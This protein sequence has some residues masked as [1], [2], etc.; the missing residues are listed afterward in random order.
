MVANLSGRSPEFY[1]YLEKLKVKTHAVKEKIR[2]DTL[3]ME[4]VPK[5]PKPDIEL[6][7]KDN[8]QFWAEWGGVEWQI[9][10]PISIGD[11]IYQGEEWVD[12]YLGNN[13]SGY[14]TKTGLEK[15]LE[16]W[17]SIKNIDFDVPW[18]KAQTMPIELADKTY[19]V[20]GIEVQE[21]PYTIDPESDFG[22]FWL[23]V[24]EEINA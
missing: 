17:P 10:V 12:R 19:K 1:K 15:Q 9:I 6:T 11:T 23:F 4:V 3:Y 8:G 2:D 20:V 14:I 5:S 21:M 22:W 24:L 7:E 18:K 16:D 13:N